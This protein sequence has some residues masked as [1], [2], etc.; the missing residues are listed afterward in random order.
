MQRE[1]NARYPS[2]K[3]LADE[4]SD[5]LDG[6][7]KREQALKVVEE[8]LELTQTREKLEEQAKKLLEEAKPD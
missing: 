4:I 7:K 6:A 5:W 1:M 8:A 3:E 2:A